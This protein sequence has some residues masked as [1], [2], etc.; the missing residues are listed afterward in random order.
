MVVGVIIYTLHIKKIHHLSVTCVLN[1]SL[2]SL[3]DDDTFAV[4]KIQLLGSKIY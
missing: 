1:V 3:F 2:V 4:Q